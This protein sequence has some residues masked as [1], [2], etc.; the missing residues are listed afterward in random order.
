MARINKNEKK[1][2]ASVHNEL[3]GLDLTINE[4]GEIIGNKKID[5]INEFLGRHVDDKKLKDRSGE[6]GEGGNDEEE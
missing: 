5:E 3:D 4:F 6:F 2:G 1:K